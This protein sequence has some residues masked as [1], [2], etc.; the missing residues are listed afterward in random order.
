MKSWQWSSRDSAFLSGGMVKPPNPP[1]CH[2]PPSASPNDLDLSL[3]GLCARVPGLW[4]SPRS[5]LPLFPRTSPT[6]RIVGNVMLQGI[7]ADVLTAYTPCAIASSLTK[8]KSMENCR[9]KM[10]A[11]PGSKKKKVSPRRE[12]KR[13][14]QAVDFSIVEARQI[15]RSVALGSQSSDA[16]TPR[17]IF[18]PSLFSS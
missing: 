12:H 3:I 17:A 1:L 13:L 4:R 14:S 7:E 15:L 10:R 2:S 16:R 9:C 11:R 6:R 8:F 5:L 18:L